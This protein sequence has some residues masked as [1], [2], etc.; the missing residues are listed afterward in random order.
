[1]AE[2]L[3]FEDVRERLDTA[4]TS[5]EEDEPSPWDDRLHLRVTGLESERELRGAL[6][7]LM[8][9]DD[10]WLIHDCDTTI[11]GVTAAFSIYTDE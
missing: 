4:F 8:Q 5:C 10:L 11:S 6:K 7:A 1:M 9:D 2:A 3:A